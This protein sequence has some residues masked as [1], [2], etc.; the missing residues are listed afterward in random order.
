MT[1]PQLKV[2]QTKQS[3]FNQKRMCKDCVFFKCEKIY[4]SFS[5][6]M[7]K[8]EACKAIPIKVCISTYSS[9][10]RIHCLQ[11]LTANRVKGFRVIQC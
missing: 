5:K 2:K 3:D 6:K 9:N 7:L 8:G 1:E 10:V 4:V 11:I